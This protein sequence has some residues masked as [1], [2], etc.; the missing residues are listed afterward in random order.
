M[1]RSRP[2][3]PVGR[4]KGAA[5]IAVMWVVILAALIL[6]SVNMEMRVHYAMAHNELAA[7]QAHWLARAGVE[8]ALA[9]LEDDDIGSDT[10]LDF[11]YEDET[12]FRDVEL[13]GGKFRVTA[14]AADEQRPTD[15]RFGLIDHSARANVNLVDAKQ[16]TSLA[17][18]SE[19]QAAAILDWRDGDDKIT[20]GGAESGYYEYLRYPY[21][22][23][24]G[25]FRTSRELLLV[26][27]IDPTVYFGEDVNDNGLLDGAEDDGKRSPPDDNADGK[28]RPGLAGLTTV[29][30]YEHN[31]DAAGNERIDLNT[32]TQQELMT[33][34]GLGEALAKAIVDHRKSNKFARVMD[35]LKVKAP[36]KSPSRGA[37]P[38]EA[39]ESS[40][41]EE[42]TNKITL[43]WIAEHLDEMT[44]SDK[45]RL[46][47]RINVNTAPRAV[48][49]T[50]P[51][52]DDAT[53]DAI[54]KQRDSAA[55]P[56]ESVGEL[57]TT[58]ALKD[59]QFQAMAELVT[60][61]SSVFEIRSTGIT[62]RGIRK[63]I[64]AV[65]D[66]GS[67]PA[68]ILYWYQSE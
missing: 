19:S 34:L 40:A 1:K 33:S 57:L 54:I 24:N 21:K 5:L 37:A 60:V 2:E 63:S 12:S 17:D 62:S 52:M 32:A 27:G 50:L 46:P 55:G 7:V 42:A 48:L 20:P 45:Q 8:Q 10:I 47:G 35:L 67:S 51:N 22:I 58:G 65:V 43:N 66:R 29:Y 9:I 16:L 15:P 3:Q 28:L 13:S 6:L 38:P 49:M 41:G 18:L 11:W 59:K 4:R 26:R 44:V 64:I 53:A 61:R 14:P 23:R 36:R 30:S 39:G 68:G 25:Q 56:F 31:R